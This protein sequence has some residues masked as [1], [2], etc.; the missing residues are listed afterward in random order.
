[1]IE[2]YV[3]YLGSACGLKPIASW[4]SSQNCH[5][6][7]DWRVVLPLLKR[8]QFNNPQQWAV[9]R[10]T[11][12]GDWQVLFLEMA[13]FGG[14]SDEL[15]SLV[16]YAWWH[17]TTRCM[18]ACNDGRWYV[19]REKSKTE[20]FTRQ[21]PMAKFQHDFLICHFASSKFGW[22]HYVV[23]AHILMISVFWDTSSCFYNFD[24]MKNKVL[25]EYTAVV[26]RVATILQTRNHNR[27]FMQVY[28]EQWD[29]SHNFH[30]LKFRCFD[31]GHKMN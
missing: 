5:I 18:N 14:E 27:F 23:T 26:L 31:S 7:G 9:I 29:I 17:F 16:N 28:T 13:Y 1:M 19:N 10:Y 2:T 21:K 15:L 20:I 30:I 22:W 12:S 24:A 11:R 3:S 8:R 6:D 25:Q 4:Y